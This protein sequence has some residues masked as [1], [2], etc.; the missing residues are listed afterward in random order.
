M[1]QWQKNLTKTQVA[2]LVVVCAVLV[3]V[4][5]KLD[6]MIETKQQSRTATKDGW[7]FDK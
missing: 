1:F 6:E 2:G 3:V 5:R 7:K 4:N